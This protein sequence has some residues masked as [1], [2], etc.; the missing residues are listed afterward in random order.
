MFIK[1]TALKLLCVAFSLQYFTA[2][3]QNITVAGTM[4]LDGSLVYCGE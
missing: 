3:A 1:S 4:G 2:N